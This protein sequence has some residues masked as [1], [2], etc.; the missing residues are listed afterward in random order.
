VF[1]FPTPEG[2]AFSP[3]ISVVDRMRSRRKE[4]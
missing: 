3:Q 2:V 1:V 4:G